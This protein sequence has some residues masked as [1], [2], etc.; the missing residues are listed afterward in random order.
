MGKFILNKLAYGILVL[1]GVVF[2][3]FALFNLLPV[4][5]ARL[6]LGQRA[7]VASVEA[8]NKELGL[9]KPFLVK[10][11][12]YL[13]DISPISVY[14]NTP[15]NQTKYHYTKIISLGESALVIKKPY[16]RRSY[17]TKELVSEKLSKALPKTII[18]ATFSII[19]A[20]I[21]GIFFGVLAAIRQHSWFDTIA[22]SIS[23]L[24]ISVPSYFSAIILAYIF[25]I[26]LHDITGLE[27]VGDITTIDDWGDE[28]LTL[29][30]LILPV[31]ALGSRPI[32]IIFQLTRSAMLDVL[33]QDYIRT[34]KAKGLSTK[35]VLFKH[36]LRNAMNPV[37]T[38][39]SGWFAG[40]L[41]G[42]FFV[43]IIFDI[44]GLGY[45]AVNSLLNF[46]FP[47]TMG[48]VLFTA[49]VFIVVNF[50]V[51]IL[52]GILDPRIRIGNK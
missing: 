7:D 27:Q 40:L 33:S 14:E 2:I 18:L 22:M 38:T 20:S 5:P 37:V 48:C 47:V 1:I 41:A 4:D 43:E 34:A 24:G 28:V 8:I 30:N 13:N 3:V 10:L 16:L 12:L 11:K 31:L 26:L 6:T 50:I 44:K 46:D 15:E 21:I 45:I 35:I 51:D 36:A 9:D 49:I 17:Q 23:N 39:V 42:A 52:Y 29:K 25:A 32:G 19:F